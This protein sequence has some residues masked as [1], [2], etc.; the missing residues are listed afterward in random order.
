M[1][2]SYKVATFLFLISASHAKAQAVEAKTEACMAT[3]LHSFML[4]LYLLN[5]F[6]SLWISKQKNI[7]FWW[8][9]TSQ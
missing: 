7:L 8:Q 1:L 4:I 9:S 5:I 2:L 6:I 3:I